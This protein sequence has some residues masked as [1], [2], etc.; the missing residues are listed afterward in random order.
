MIYYCAKAGITAT[1]IA[2]VIA[3]GGA[4]ALGTIFCVGCKKGTDETL[5]L[6]V[7]G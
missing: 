4:V 7:E 2:A 3:I 5:N 1:R 6:E